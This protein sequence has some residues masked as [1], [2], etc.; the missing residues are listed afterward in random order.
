VSDWLQVSGTL[1]A[2]PARR[3][4]EAGSYLW[5]EAGERAEAVVAELFLPAVYPDALDA[6]MGVA[7]GS[8]QIGS[9]QRLGD[10]QLHFG[11]VRG[12]RGVLSADGRVLKADVSFTLHHHHPGGGFCPRCGGPLVVEPVAVITPPDGGLIASPVARCEACGEA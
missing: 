3:G 6:A 11:R 9:E 8:V 2:L 1:C 10:V 7:T 5:L 12:D 4:D